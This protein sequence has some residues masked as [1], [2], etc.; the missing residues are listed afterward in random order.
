MQGGGGR[1]G[2]GVRESRRTAQI[3]HFEHGVPVGL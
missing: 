3:V 2:E 1:H